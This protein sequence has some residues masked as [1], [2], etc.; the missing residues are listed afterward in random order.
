MSPIGRCCQFR[1]KGSRP[2]NRGAYRRTVLSA[3][4]LGASP[5]PLR[6]LSV[7]IRSRTIGRSHQEPLHPSIFA[8][9]QLTG[10]SGTRTR[11]VSTST[12]FI[13]ASPNTTN[14]LSISNLSRSK[15]T[16]N[17][18]SRI[19]SGLLQR[20]QHNP[21]QPAHKKTLPAP[22]G[23]RGRSETSTACLLMSEQRFEGPKCGYSAEGPTVMQR[24]SNSP[25]C[26]SRSFA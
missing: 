14:Y 16:V 10:C 6:P 3:T 19:G 22:L 13:C 26:S 20:Q 15:T 4:P 24:K 21:H 2:V 7:V 1:S 23:G 12:I 17:D 11:N 25:R 18:K 8:L 9:C 5:N